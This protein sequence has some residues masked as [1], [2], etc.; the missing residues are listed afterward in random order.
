MS[1]AQCIAWDLDDRWPCCSGTLPQAA[2]DY[3]INSYLRGKTGIYVNLYSPSRASWKQNGVKCSLLQQTDYPR[4]NRITLTVST[5]SSAAFAIYLRIPA[6]A[7]KGTSA[8]VNG[9]RLTAGPTPGAFFAIDRTWKTGDRI[10]LEI[11]QPLRF[12][13]VDAQTPGQIAIVR[14]AQVL[15]AIQEEQPRIT[16]ADIQSA[17]LKPAANADWTLQTAAGPLTLRPFP[18]IAN[19]NY[20]TYSALQ[21]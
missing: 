17:E 16:G 7:G 6:W 3:G 15:F 10:E 21:L 4:G 9:R 13:P 8:S 11:A 14:G 5:A 1:P 12:E 18:A 19:E 2:A 20:Y